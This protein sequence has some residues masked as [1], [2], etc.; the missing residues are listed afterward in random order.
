VQQAIADDLGEILLKMNH[1]LEME[2]A[3]L[4]RETEA[5]KQAIRRRELLEEAAGLI[6]S[7]AEDIQHRAHESV[8]Q[9]VTRCLQAVFPD[10]YE[11]KIVFERK[12]GK[13]EGRFTFL[14][15]GQDIDPQTAVGGGVLDVA[16]FGLRVACLMLSKPRKRRIL[17]LDEPFKYVSRNYLG[18]VVQ[19]LESLSE[20]ME[21]QIIMVTHLP[22][23]E[24]GKLVELQ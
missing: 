17:F 22:E 9:V 8:A 11:F 15:E 7:I 4:A 20:E 1:E 2:K 10:P 19:L 16:S 21:M 24:V 23:L 12:R 6:N 3:R 13:T 18:N 14:R 5:I